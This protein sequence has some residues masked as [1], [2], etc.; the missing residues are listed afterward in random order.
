LY[1]SYFCLPN[2]FGIYA[3]RK[4]FPNLAAERTTRYDLIELVEDGLLAKAGD[5]KS[6]KYI[7][8]VKLPILPLKQNPYF[9]HIPKF[10]TSE[11]LGI[12]ILVT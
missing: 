2:V 3:E 12:F 1:N 8:A 6:T 10:P 7:F 5:K 9:P 4:A 11:D